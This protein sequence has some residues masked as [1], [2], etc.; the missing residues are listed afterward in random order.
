MVNKPSVISKY[1]ERYLIFV[2]TCSLMHPE[3]EKFFN[4]RLVP[5]IKQH[6]FKYPKNK[7]GFYIINNVFSLCVTS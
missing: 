3:A 4:A 2:D 1:V 6:N 5:K 7:T